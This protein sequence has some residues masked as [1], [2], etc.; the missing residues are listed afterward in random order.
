ME[1]TNVLSDVLA[2]I[3][4]TVAE[5]NRIFSLFDPNPHSGET[6]GMFSEVADG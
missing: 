2:V 1:I 3:A 5:R 6:K 4:E